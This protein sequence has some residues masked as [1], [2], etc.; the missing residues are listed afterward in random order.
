MSRA[1]WLLSVVCYVFMIFLYTN[2]T[3]HH[4]GGHHIFAGIIS[5]LFILLLVVGFIGMLAA[6]KHYW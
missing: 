6:R 1:F 5:A 2:S 3:I 4:F